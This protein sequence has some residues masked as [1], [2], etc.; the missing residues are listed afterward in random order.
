MATITI[1]WTNEA[2]KWLQEIHDHIAQDSPAA[3]LRVVTAIYEKTQVIKDFPKIGYLYKKE[4]EG[5]IRILLYGHYRIAYLN[6]GNDL[7]DI[8]GIFHG[9]MEIEEY[10]KGEPL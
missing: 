8:L 7:T 5:E 3:A 6:K 2:Q 10:L 1:R 4:T 9:A